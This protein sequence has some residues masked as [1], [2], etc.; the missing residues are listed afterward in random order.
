MRI[1]KNNFLFFIDAFGNAHN[2]TDRAH[3][4]REE[5]RKSPRPFTF[6]WIARKV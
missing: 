2:F 4:G 1:T 3:G 6:E 5:F